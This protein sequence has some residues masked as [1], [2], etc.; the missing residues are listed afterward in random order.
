MRQS[1]Q[2]I[3]LRFMYD[4]LFFLYYPRIMCGQ[5]IMKTSWKTSMY[6][7]EVY[8]PHQTTPSQTKTKSKQETFQ[9]KLNNPL[10]MN[11]WGLTSDT[12]STIM[13]G[14]ARLRA[15]QHFNFRYPWNGELCYSKKPNNKS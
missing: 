2:Y 4:F 8:Y 15:N 9:P 14:S 3:P 5:T 1:G 7:N 11:F 10:A 6:N 13:Y 12:L